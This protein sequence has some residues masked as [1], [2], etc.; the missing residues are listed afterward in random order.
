MFLRPSGSLS[1]FSGTLIF[2]GF[3]NLRK[4]VISVHGTVYQT[5]EVYFFSF[6]ITSVRASNSSNQTITILTSSTLGPKL[7]N[8]SCALAAFFYRRKG[9]LFNFSLQLL[10]LAPPHFTG[11]CFYI[12]VAVL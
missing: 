12:F 10:A 2:H 8:V 7:V 1:H 5:R 11:Q 3:V 4:N 9:F 6:L